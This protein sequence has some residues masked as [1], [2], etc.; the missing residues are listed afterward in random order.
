MDFDSS[1]T[2]VA[3]ILVGTFVFQGSAS[4]SEVPG[5]AIPVS[6]ENLLEMQRCRAQPRPTKSETWGGV[7]QSSDLTNLP[8]GSDALK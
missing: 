2:V 6:P 7:Q 3:L 8:E 4:H 1:M 5:P